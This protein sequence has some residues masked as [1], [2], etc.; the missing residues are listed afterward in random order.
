MAFFTIEFDYTGN[1]PTASKTYNLCIND[2][3]YDAENVEEVSPI[4]VNIDGSTKAN[5]LNAINTALP[6]TRSGTTYRVA[7]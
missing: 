1:A 7:S 2:L 4:K 5:I 3:G 6:K